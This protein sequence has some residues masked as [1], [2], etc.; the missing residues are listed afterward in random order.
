M[1]HE[2]GRHT[3]TIEPAESVSASYK[4]LMKKESTVEQDEKLPLVEKKEKLTFNRQKSLLK[5]KHK[6]KQKSTTIDI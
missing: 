4:K 3:I 2:G 1:Y 6:L 5:V